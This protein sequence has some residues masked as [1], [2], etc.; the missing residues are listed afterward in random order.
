[1]SDEAARRYLASSKDSF[2]E[3]T[4]DGKTIVWKD[5]S[6]ITFVEELHSLLSNFLSEGLPPFESF[7]L[8][9]AATRTSFK[10]EAKQLWARIVPQRIFESDFDPNEV[11]DVLKGINELV[12][13]WQSTE[14]RSRLLFF[15]LGD[16]PAVE[17]VDSHQVLKFLKDGLDAETLQG[18]ALRPTRSPAIGAAFAKMAS[19]LDLLT[20][21]DILD[22]IATGIDFVPVADEDLELPI[23]E[24]VRSLLRELTEEEGDLAGIAQACKHLMAVVALP[25][26]I[27]FDD[28]MPIGGVSDITNRGPLD[29]LLL[30]ELAHDDLTL[31]VRVAVNEAMYLRRESPP[32]SPPQ[33]RTILL[34]CGIRTWGVPRIYIA[35]TALAILSQSDARGELT[36]RSL[37]GDFERFCRL[38]VTTREGLTEHLKRLSPSLHPGKPLTDWYLQVSKNAPE[39]LLD[40]VLITTRDALDDVDFRQRLRE[41]DIDRMF[42]AVV[43]HTGEFELLQ[44]S[45]A[46]LKSLRKAKLDLESISKTRRNAESLIDPTKSAK[47]PAIYRLKRH[48][49]AGYSGVTSGSVGRSVFPLRLTENASSSRAWS[50]D[51]VGAFL[52]TKDGRL[53]FF[54][55]KQHGGEQ[56][57]DAR[58][59]AVV[60]WY[61]KRVRDGKLYAV[62]TTAEYAR[63]QF[64]TIDVA[65]RQAT[66]ETIEFPRF[67]QGFCDHNGQLFAVSSRDVRTISL[68]PVS[69]GES[70]GIPDDLKW[71]SDFGGRT[72]SIDYL[73]RQSNWHCL[74]SGATPHFEQIFTTSEFRHVFEHIHHEG[75][76]G[77]NVDGSI[78]DISSGNVWLSV[79]TVKGRGLG[80]FHSVSRCGRYVSYEYP[81][82][83][84]IVFLINPDTPARFWGIAPDVYPLTE[85]RTIKQRLKQLPVRKRL[86][87][88]GIS[89]PVL[90]LSR[91]QSQTNY[92]G[93]EGGQLRILDSAGHLVEKQRANFKPRK[94]ADANFQ[95]KVATF[96]GGSEVSLDS[97]GLLH[98]KSSDP[99]IP[100][101]TIV[102]HD[103]VAGWTTKQ[104][105]FGHDYF[106]PADANVI[107]AADFNTNVLERFVRRCEEDQLAM[108]T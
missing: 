60:C 76:L 68:N 102:L 11:L 33:N 41:V 106:L 47:L 25:R 37:S 39:E 91:D 21:T 81:G 90:T 6:T 42:L 83:N 49:V 30:S 26:R 17:D 85:G 43:D 38:D 84:K 50:V 48:D 92:L 62:L 59:G 4:D 1:M 82:D 73:G 78:V 35:A 16:V 94:I 10:D 18:D 23:P 3:W 70:T 58:L 56:L 44:R 31:A 75:F 74:S 86:I 29:R 28:K 15:L 2:W 64:V 99:S 89:P 87:S 57:L 54:E 71:R 12:E 97:R 77:V 67:L 61:S 7:L 53:L 65:S 96:E 9:I 103:H 51:D 22:R 95:L 69:V 20:S 14:S 108:R 72:F 19:K 32:E 34:D 98:L 36:V 66:C 40:P 88:V 52:I 45:A 104:E 93:L 55:N 107:S 79:E 5:G 13:L 105:Y 63:Y 80:E 46:G 101:A 27:T 24:K 100:E 8:V